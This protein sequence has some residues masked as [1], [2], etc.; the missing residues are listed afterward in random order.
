MLN[1]QNLNNMKK[2]KRNLH[3][4]VVYLHRR[5]ISKFTF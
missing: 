4:F 3:N 5:N 2:T 1:K